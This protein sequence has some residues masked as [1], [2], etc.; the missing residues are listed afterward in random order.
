MRRFTEAVIF[1][2]L[3]M[4][5]SCEKGEFV[6]CSD[7]VEEE[8]VEADIVADLDPTYFY[9][10]IVQIWEGNL[11]D[12]LL[13]GS[14][15]SYSKTFSHT[16]T[17]NKKYTVTAKYYVRMMCTLLSIQ[18]HQESGILIHSVRIHAITCTT[19]NATLD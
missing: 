18:Q 19:R 2:L 6:K 8:P 10:A 14:F 5:F 12:S 15:T 16:V 3:I 4:V 9:S 11:E 7:C 1:L 17:L 13:V